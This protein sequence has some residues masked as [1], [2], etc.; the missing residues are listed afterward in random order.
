MLKKLLL[1]ISICTYSISTNS[2]HTI[3]DSHSIARKWNEVLLEAIRK[4]F[5]RPTVHARNLFHSSVA[6]YDTW[7]LYNLE[8]S[9]PYFAKQYN[10]TE[11]LSINTEQEKNDAIIKTMSYA[12]YNLIKHRF[13]N[14]PRYFLTE[15]N[16]EALM[17]HLNLDIADAD[18]S[19]NNEVTPVTLGNLIASVIIEFGL[20]D[21][22]NEIDEYSNQ[23]YTPSNPFLAP[24][25]SGNSTITN[26]DRWQPLSLQVFID[27]GGNIVFGE[28]TEFLSAEWG[29]VTPFSLTDE[30]YVTKTRNGNEY[31][32]YNDPDSPP[33]LSDAT[34]AEFYKWGFSLV[35]IWGSHLTS[36]D[37]TLIDIS[38]GAMGDINIADFPK[39]YADYPNFYNLKDG[40]D[41]G[42]G[43]TMNPISNTSYSPNLVKRGDYARVIAEFW[44]DGPDSETPPGHWYTILNEKVS[45]RIQNKKIAGNDA[46]VDDLE[47][48]V[49]SYFLLGGAMHDAAISAWS[50]KGWYDYIRPISSIRYM[51][52]LGQ[53]TDNTL[54]NYHEDGIPLVE[55][56]VEV[57][58]NEDPLS[59]DQNQNVGKIKVYTWKGHDYASNTDYAGVDW[60]LAENWWPY[61]RPSF[62][63]PPFAGYVSGHSTFSRAAAKVL[64]LFTGSEYFPEGMGTHLAKQNEFLVFEEGPSEDIELQWATY[65]DASDQCSL[66][67]IWGGIHP[68][69]DDIP[70][71]FIG[72]NVGKKAY[73]FGI[74]YFK[75]YEIESE[76]PVA[77]PN[78]ISI[79]KPL[80]II[81]TN[82]ND[83]FELYN[84]VG[85]VLQFQTIYFNEETQR[86]ELTFT[87]TTSGIYFIKHNDNKV[88][89]VI[90]Q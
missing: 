53:S 68:P 13:K 9:T 10:I 83:T 8:K 79:N 12:M 69:A 87:P 26:P 17:E 47:W 16:I 62:V 34:T 14:S 40:G 81:N 73:D 5:A 42:T 18:L 15:R 25:N 65:F 23:F 52:D 24:I 46:N 43:R 86:T 41:I 1:L 76:N 33:F 31:K 75:P 54:A 7:A 59:G 88:Y 57:V 20:T 78:P 67:R 28:E 6:M 35:S 56:L 45:D 3:D 49:K 84:S 27:Q 36:E 82:D 55:G 4:D 37:N 90:I 38:P 44:A 61:Q 85:K 80:T 51:A 77:Y 70:G 89:K 66:S 32:V 50:V 64:T 48:D 72:E 11:S 22:S 60:I 29:N 74:K 19:Y 71:R 58:E 39:N 63:T 21:G 30:D 2:Q